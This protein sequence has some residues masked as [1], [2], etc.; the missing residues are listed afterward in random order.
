MPDNLN[1]DI[2]WK[3]LGKQYHKE[4]GQGLNHRENIAPILPENRILRIKKQLISIDKTMAD[5]TKWRL[6]PSS[7]I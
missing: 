4:T 3:P 5:F 7:G 2:T 6:G 1:C